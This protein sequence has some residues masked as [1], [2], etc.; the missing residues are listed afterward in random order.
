MEVII[1]VDEIVYNYANTDQRLRLDYLNDYLASGQ[2]RFQFSSYDSLDNRYYFEIPFF[3]LID[4][5]GLQV[6]YAII[7]NNKKRYH[8]RINRQ[9]NEIVEIDWND[10]WELVESVP[11]NLIKF[12]YPSD[13]TM[14]PFIGVIGREIPGT[15]QIPEPEA[16]INSLYIPVKETT[17]LQVL[18]E[19]SQTGQIIEKGLFYFVRG[20]IF[21]AIVAT[22]LIV[23]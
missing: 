14:V 7:L 15:I 20:T 21:L 10:N 18:F 23:R 4:V 19:P 6:P 1:T 13:Y 8:F 3:P 17:E 11:D 5:P 2:M 16:N 9:Y 22:F 12:E